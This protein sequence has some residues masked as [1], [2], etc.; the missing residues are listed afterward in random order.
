MQ[1]DEPVHTPWYT[2]LAL[3]QR[4]SCASTHSRWRHLRQHSRTTGPTVRRALQLVQFLT[5]ES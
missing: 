2:A 3:R 5:C 1:A 4:W